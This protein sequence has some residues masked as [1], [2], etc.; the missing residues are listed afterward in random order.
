M[1]EKQIMYLC[2]L[3]PKYIPVYCQSNDS[4]DLEIG[5]EFLLI[6]GKRYHMVWF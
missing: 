3:H 1:N 6:L 4:N 5:N 2:P